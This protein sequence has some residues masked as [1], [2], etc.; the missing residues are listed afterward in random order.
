MGKWMTGVWVNVG[1]WMSSQL[2]G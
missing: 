2:Y 1:K